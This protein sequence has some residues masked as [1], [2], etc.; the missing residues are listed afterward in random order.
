M[1]FDDY[2]EHNATKR[3]IS[4]MRCIEGWKFIM[5]QKEVMRVIDCSQKKNLNF[6]CVELFFK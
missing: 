5:K 1:F 2:D 6:K 3:L 4:N